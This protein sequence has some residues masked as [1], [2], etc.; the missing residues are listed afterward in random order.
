MA[1]KERNNAAKEAYKA[2]KEAEM[3]LSLILVH[4]FLA[5]RLSGKE[6]LKNGNKCLVSLLVGFSLVRGKCW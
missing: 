4:C 3:F 2:I 5:K 6:Q 1:E